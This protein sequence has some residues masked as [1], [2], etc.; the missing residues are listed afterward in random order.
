M[1]TRTLFTP[2]GFG[3][4]LL[5][6]SLLGGLA[7]P[8]CSTHR[9]ILGQVVDRNGKAV[10]RANVTVT[11]G[12][13]EIIT[14]DD[15]RFT[16]DYLRDAE[17]TRVKLGKRTEYTVEFFKVGFH[18]EKATIFYTKGDLAMDPVTLTEDTVRVAAS[19][20]QFDPADHPDR[21]QDAGGSYEGE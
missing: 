16:V 3:W 9:A 13:V 19:S 4:S 11:P 6:A 8:G 14:D 10:G 15:G 5:A 20:T 21:G 2:R 1:I 18:P 17:G 12:N 7:L